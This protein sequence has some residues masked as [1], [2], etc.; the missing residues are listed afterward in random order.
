MILKKS[1]VLLKSGNLDKCMTLNDTASTNLLVPYSNSI[2]SHTAYVNTEAYVNSKLSD[3]TLT[4]TITSVITPATS[5]SVSLV[6]YKFLPNNRFIAV[7][8]LNGSA[9]TSYVAGIQF[10]VN[11]NN[12]YVSHSSFASTNSNFITGCTIIDNTLYTGNG[13]GSQN[14]AFLCSYF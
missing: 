7:L 12:V 10:K 2:D 1:N 14:V 6:S 4:F 13:N 5:M 11:G 3:R 9:A 8:N